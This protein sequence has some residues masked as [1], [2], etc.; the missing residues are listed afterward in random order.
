MKCIRIIMVLMAIM[1]GQ[2][3]AF[4]QEGGQTEDTPAHSESQ[5]WKGIKVDTVLD[6]SKYNPILVDGKYTGGKTIFLYNMGT[7]KFIIEG[8][9]FGME[10]RLFHEDF[11]RPLHLFSDGYITSGITEN[12][13]KY[14]FGCNIPGVFHKEAGWTDTN[15]HQYSFT[16]MMD[17]DKS[18]RTKGWQ[19][20][21]VDGETG[22]TCTYYIYEEKNGKKYYLGAAWG[23]C[24]ASAWKGDGQYVSMDADR[25]TWT[26]ANP[27]GNMDKKEV[28]GDMIAIDELYKWRV[29]SEEEFIDALSKEE[30]GLNPSISIFVPDRDFTRNA[31]NFD[32]N[33]VMEEKPD[34]DYYSE[35]GRFGYTFGVY[36]NKQNQQQYNK[37][38]NGKNNK[39]FTND[40]WNKPIRLKNVFDNSAASGG[41]DLTYGWE[42]AKNGFL[43]F[44]GV[45]RTYTTFTVPKPGWYQIQCYGFVRSDEGHNAYLFAKVVGGTEASAHG[46]EAKNNLVTVPANK[47]K[48][49]NDVFK[50]FRDSCLVV[51]NLLRKPS[52]KEP[53]KNTVWICVTDEEYG[54]GK[55]TL[56]VGVGKD[57][58]TK[59][60]GVKSGNEY[61][62]YDTD[63]VCIDDIRV[64]YLGTSPAFFYEEEE[65]LDYLI[66]GSE[67]TK[68]FETSSPSS[69]G[70]PQGQYGGAVCIERSL[71]TGQWNSFSFPL[72]L[73]GEQMRHAFGEDAH[74]AKIHSIGKMSKNPNVIDF[75]TVSL[76]T[77]DEVVSP[78][79]FY[80]LK[81]TMEPTTGIDPRGRNTKFY[82][83]GRFFFSVNE[84]ES[85]DYKH[86]ILPLGTLKK[87]EQAIES[88]DSDNDGIGDNDGIASVNYVQTPGF[89]SFTVSGE[90]IYNGST[91]VKGIYAPK[92]SYVVSNNTILHLTKDTRIKGFRGWIE[93]NQPLTTQ[94]KD[95]TMEVFGMFDEVPEEGGTTSVPRIHLF[96]ADESVYDL[97]GRKMGKLG[98]TL[99]KG[100]YI[101]KGKKYMVK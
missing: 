47:F 23:E 62:Y 92:G 51:G 91:D 15:W 61:Y 3:V 77:T 88:L 13:E 7:G 32:T 75:K 81:P 70:G 50:N 100:I 98:D 40:A 54:S 69:F 9:N 45:G 89:S 58:A 29:V 78:D 6:N 84:N 42:N 52:T 63:W 43:T 82:E 80:L 21:R 22:D 30:V 37:E 8:G 64:S 55:K 49:N 39:Y 38:Q 101:V 11:G 16:I 35:T 17:A 28:D 87:E 79:S 73:T 90:Y 71:K 99:P 10:G 20:K 41:P 67:N 93:L 53:Y 74:L 2:G 31:N 33:W 5:K 59:S 85:E 26:S 19:F 65:N 36:L 60:T 86:E 97:Y 72:P 56:Q 76:R 34:G 46:G 68:Q 66:P 83:L 48:Y 95:F 27:V 57:Q 18:R 25:C 44:E 12:G 96:T 4:A 14:L 24:H 1:F 94:S